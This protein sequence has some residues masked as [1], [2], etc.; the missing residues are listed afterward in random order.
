[1]DSRLHYRIERVFYSLERFLLLLPRFLQRPIVLRRMNERLWNLLDM[2]AGRIRYDYLERLESS[3]A[4]FENDLL[5]SS[6]HGDCQS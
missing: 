5:C 2:N 4:Q 1:V 3:M 6:H